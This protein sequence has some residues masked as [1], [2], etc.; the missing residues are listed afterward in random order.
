VPHYDHPPL[1]IQA[2]QR[3]LHVMV[4]KPAGVYARQVRQM[5]EAAKKSGRA[6]GIMFNKRTSPIF[7]KLKDILSAGELGSIKRVNYTTSEFYRCQAYYDS[8][9][10]RGTWAGEGGGLLLNQCPHTLDLWQLLCGVPVRVRAFCGY[11][12]YR[13]I[14][15]EDEV[16]AYVEYANGATGLLISSVSESPGT[17]RLEI[18]GDMGKIVVEDEK[19]IV[20]WRNRQ[21]EKEF[22]ATSTSAFGRPEA[23]ICDVPVEEPQNEAHQG[24]Q[25]IAQNWIN[26][27][28]KGE[29]LIVPGEEG[30]NSIQIS[31][32]IHL[33]SWLDDW[34]EIPVDEDLFY[35]KLQE[36]IR[37]STRAKKNV[38][39][40]I[41][42]DITKSF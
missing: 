15:V 20:F 7:R 16:T 34:A 33:S 14:E 5:N 9:E 2:F 28:L 29:P 4:E 24:H 23:W 17:N 27:I 13:N 6:F 26:S 31:N 41:E 37:G 3:G 21:S 39:Q 42:E 12:K 10:W 18:V 1:A 38:A 25:K 11:G 36:K 8:G 30:I 40:K 35:T 32:A 22:N 19:K